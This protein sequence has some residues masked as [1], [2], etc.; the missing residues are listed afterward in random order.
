[1]S[2]YI[3]R[4]SA[5]TTLRGEKNRKTEN[6]VSSDF[7][8]VRTTYGIVSAVHP[9][10]VLIRAISSDGSPLIGDNWIPLSHSPREIAERFGTVQKKMIVMIQY[11]GVG[12]DR[13]VAT[14]VRESGEEIANLQEE[15]KLQRGLFKIFA[16]GIGLG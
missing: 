1:M 11:S 14:I 12:E 16:P 7:S 10:R 8:V 4:T 3:Q 6:E 9:E 13:A 5:A 15:N 2:G